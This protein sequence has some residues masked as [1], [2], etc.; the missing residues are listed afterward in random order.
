MPTATLVSVLM[1]VAMSPSGA[2]K[3]KWCYKLGSC[4][5]VFAED[6]KLQGKVNEGIAIQ[7]KQEADHHC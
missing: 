2:E 4:H 7:A 1:N 6:V 3:T 5:S